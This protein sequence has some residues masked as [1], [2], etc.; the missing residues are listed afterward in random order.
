MEDI[1]IKLE[2]LSKPS[3]GIAEVKKYFKVSDNTAREYISKAIDMFGGQ[4]R[5]NE[6][7][8]KRQIATSDS[9]LQLM[10]AVSREVESSILSNII[11]GL[12]SDGSTS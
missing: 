5:Y 11:R 4:V 8:K 12:K 3:W 6:D 10:G 2:L 9:I 7:F 1:K